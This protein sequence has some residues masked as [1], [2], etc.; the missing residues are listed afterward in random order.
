[1]SLLVASQFLSWIAIGMLGA[2]CLA[3]ARQVGILHERIAPAGALSIKSGVTS[4]EAAP[5][6]SVQTIAGQ[7]VTI[8]GKRTGRSQLLFF[9]SPDCPVCKAL[10]PA[11]KAAAKSE[12]SWLDVILVSDGPG[13]AHEK[14]VRAQGLYDYPYIVSEMVGRS[15][16]VSKL[17]FGTLIDDAGTVRA[18]GLINTRE[19]LDSLFEAKE[20]KVASIQEFLDQRQHASA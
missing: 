10:L 13:E 9:I 3:L 1:M 12:T 5:E 19:H 7:L 11:L 15:F 18:S 14:F 8:G 17:P 16:G 20:R 6:L 4:G 2:L